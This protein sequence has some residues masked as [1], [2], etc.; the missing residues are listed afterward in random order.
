MSSW[1]NTLQ[2]IQMRK[3][4]YALLGVM[5]ATYILLVFLTPVNT[6]VLAKY[7][8]TVLQLRIID[9][10]LLLPLIA[11][12]YI[13]F[14]GF[15]TMKE[16]VS[17]I[18]DEPDGKGFNL[19]ASGLAVLAIGMVVNSIL[20]TITSVMTVHDLRL[21]PA[22]VIVGNY[23]SVILGAASFYLI[24]KGSVELK[25]LVRI[26]PGE[27]SMQLVSVAFGALGAGFAYL[28]VTNPD[29]SAAAT[30]TSHGVF[31]LPNWLILVSVVL[32]YLAMWYAG[33]LAAR[34]IGHYRRN[35]KGVIYR[36][37]LK[38]LGLGVSTIIVASVLG[39]MLSLFPRSFQNMSL[40]WVLAVIAV[41]LGVIAAGFVMVAIGAKKLRQLEGV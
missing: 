23:M 18:K 38:N 5:V 10:F 31:Y 13:A 30:A 40:S 24:Y 1:T 20:S 39:Q 19:L 33:L 32:P 21:V 25:Q 3:K 36:S 41:L 16:Y 8:I 27:G 9:V 17:H 22:G 14:Y 29:R 11:I 34:N 12:Y 28:A 2:Y 7:H 26:R 35:I 15:I 37:L 6:A 4:Y